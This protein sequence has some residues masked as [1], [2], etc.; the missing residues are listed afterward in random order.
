M[1]AEHGGIFRVNAD[2]GEAEFVGRGE[3]LS[4]TVEHPFDGHALRPHLHASPDGQF[5]AIVNDHGR[6]GR[7]IDLRSGNVTLALDGGDYC[8][9]TVPFSFAFAAWEE[10]IVAIHRTA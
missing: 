5:A 1:L 7:V 10:R 2:S 3:I 6:Y 8:S 4:E 9:E